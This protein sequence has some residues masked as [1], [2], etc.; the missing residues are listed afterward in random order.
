MRPTIRMRAVEARA[1]QSA[2]GAAS[3]HGAGLSPAGT[4]PPAAEG[5]GRGEAEASESP[6]LRR[7]E[8]RT[9]S[10]FRYYGIPSSLWVWAEPPA[11]VAP[12][13]VQRD[14]VL[15]LAPGAVERLQV[16]HLE[17]EALDVRGSTSCG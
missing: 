3:D 12:A 8:L 17:G 2:A 14:A 4:G 1:L 9:E 16:E 10:P 7:G 6:R 13:V 11:R 15:S 5:E